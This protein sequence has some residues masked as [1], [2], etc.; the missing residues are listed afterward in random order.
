VDELRSIVAHR[1]GKALP[2]VLDV[3]DGE[4]GCIANTGVAGC[5]NAEVVVCASCSKSSTMDA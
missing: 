1:D 5:A 3:I 2:V 4:V